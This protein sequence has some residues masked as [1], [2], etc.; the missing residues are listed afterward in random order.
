[1]LEMFCSKCGKEIDKEIDSDSKLCGS[2]C[3]ILNTNLK[4]KAK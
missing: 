2:C 3:A 4:T 1:M